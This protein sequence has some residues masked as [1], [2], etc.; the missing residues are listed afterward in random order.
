VCIDPERIAKR[1]DKNHFSYLKRL[2]IYNLTWLQKVMSF[3]FNVL[4]TKEARE[5][6]EQL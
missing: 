2:L 4:H 3:K 6:I 5:M 1:E